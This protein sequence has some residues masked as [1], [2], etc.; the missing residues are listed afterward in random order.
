MATIDI[1]NPELAEAIKEL[2]EHKMFNRHTK[3]S[4]TNILDAEFSPEI[5][6][7]FIKSLVKTMDEGYEELMK[8]FGG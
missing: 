6:K 7:M 5:T 8:R 1:T 2:M 3:E 4:L